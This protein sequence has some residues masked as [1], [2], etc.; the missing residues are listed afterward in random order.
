MVNHQASRL[1]TRPE[2]EEAELSRFT[3]QDVQVPTLMPAGQSAG[4][5]GTETD[6]AGAR[7]LSALIGLDPVREALRVRLAGL[8]RL[9]R[10]QQPT[11][12]LANLVFEGWDGAGRGSVAA[13]YA[14]CLAEDGLIASGTLRTVRLSEFPVLDPRQAHVFAQHAFEDSAGGVLLLRLDDAFFQRSAE[15]REGVL[16]ALRPAMGRNPAVVL[17]L[18]GEPHRVAQILR[19]RPD[20]AG[21]FADSLTFPEYGAAG[22]AR[23]AARHLAVRGF[24]LGQQTIERIAAFFGPA[25][26]RTGAWDV[27]RFAAN[28]AATARSTVI[29]PGDVGRPAPDPSAPA[30]AAQGQDA[31]HRTGELVHP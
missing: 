31:D 28:L 3:P 15:Q 21:C 24:D 10:E 23:L 8:A 18:A 20:V 29:E 25:P 12:G 9:R 16:A 13:I 26:A 22:L 14:Q 11:A 27:H 2:A 19:E 5:Q 1:A 7:R 17:L 6:T 30:A 4:G